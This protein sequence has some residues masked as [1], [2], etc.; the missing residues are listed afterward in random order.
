MFY[1]QSSKSSYLEGILYYFH[2]FCP[3]LCSLASLHSISCVLFPCLSFSSRCLL[4]FYTHPPSSQLPRSHCNQSCNRA[5]FTGSSQGPASVT[6]L[7]YSSPQPPFP[8]L[9]LVRLQRKQQKIFASIHTARHISTLK[10][11]PTPCHAPSAM[12]DQ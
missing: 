5:V 10:S 6:H 3:L 12:L 8:P 1:Y 4:C 2:L 9:T 11:A 7:L